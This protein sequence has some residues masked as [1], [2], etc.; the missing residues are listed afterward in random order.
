MPLPFVSDIE[1]PSHQLLVQK[2]L[3][4]STSPRSLPVFVQENI[5]GLQGSG[6]TSVNLHD[7]LV[8]CHGKKSY[9]QLATVT[10]QP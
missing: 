5:F 4:A 2:S 8:T 9:G 7:V 6:A 10:G 1:A 3:R